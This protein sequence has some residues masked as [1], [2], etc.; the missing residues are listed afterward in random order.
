M[1]MCVRMQSNYGT[2]VGADACQRGGGSRS[3]CKQV[4]IDVG[5][6]SE[7]DREREKRQ[8]DKTRLIGYYDER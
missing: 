5:V 8:P 6:K 2:E 3:Y 7:A 4:G 1:C